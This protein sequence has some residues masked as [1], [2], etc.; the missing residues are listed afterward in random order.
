MTEDILR[1]HEVSK[2]EGYWVG[3]PSDARQYRFGMTCLKKPG[4]Q[5]AFG[6]SVEQAFWIGGGLQW[7]EIGQEEVGGRKGGGFGSL[8]GWTF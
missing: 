4:P 1:W 7:K 2:D 8:D 3:V 5:P 6:I